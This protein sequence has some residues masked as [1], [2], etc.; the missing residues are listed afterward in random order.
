MSLPWEFR[1]TAAPPLPRPP[2]P[3]PSPDGV[4]PGAESKGVL[5]AVLMDEGG[6]VSEPERVENATP[7]L[8]TERVADVALRRE[9][10]MDDTEDEEVARIN[11]A[12]GELAPPV[13]ASL[14][15]WA[16]PRAEAVAAVSWDLLPAGSWSPF[17]THSEASR[18][19]LGSTRS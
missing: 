15:A 16:L 14:S 10:D 18:Q 5:G 2:S 1:G 17:I 8:V 9:P 11:D 12:A 3:S 6:T 7:D 19:G 4:P 13:S